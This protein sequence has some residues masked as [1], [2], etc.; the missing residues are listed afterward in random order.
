MASTTDPTSRHPVP[1]KSS[2]DPSGVETASSEKVA[3]NLTVPVPAPDSPDGGTRAWL[4][5]AG[6]FLVFAN[7]WGMPFAFGNF[8]SYYELTYLTDM[9]AST[10]S[11][12][13]T[14]CAFLLVLG[15]VA[16]GPLFD[17]GYFRSMLIAGA[18]IETLSVF[19]LSLCTE[20]YQILLTQGILAGLGNSLL[21][22]P[23]LALVSRAFTKR[24]ALAMGITTCGAPFGSIAYTLTFQRLIGHISFG[25]TVRIMGSVMLASYGIAFPL[26]L[27]RVN[28]LG[29]ISSGQTRKHFDKTAF[30]DL[31]FWTF[32]TSGF[33]IS[34]GYL[35]PFYYMA[36]YGQ[37]E[38]GMERSDANYVIIY[39]QAASIVG[40][41]LASF[42][43]AR[44][45]VMIPWITCAACSGVFCIAW[46][47][48]KTPGSFIAYA[49][50]YGCFSGALIPLAP[51]VFPVVCPDVDVLG[52]R[53]GMAEGIMSFANLIGSPIAG[54]L[55]QI[56]ARDGKQNYLGLQLFSGLIMIL[57]AVNLCMLWVLLIR[58]RDLRSKLI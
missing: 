57:G 21:F 22:I 32:T 30:K 3:T 1:S 5:V 34:C 43:A 56:N 16:S 47:G 36:S 6:S 12:I 4:Q 53:L 40:R 10:I 11:W 31:P 8:Q 27:W 49:V 17:L 9:D 18:F 20:Y 58:Q 46:I 42:A 51:S 39:A 55:A 45:G 50:L 38:L 37:I 13:G 52:A 48:V 41:L 29:D 19:L 33:L 44:I 35:V 2:D 23:G 54:A 28:N 25:W 14:I 24:R 15:G 26:L 7:L